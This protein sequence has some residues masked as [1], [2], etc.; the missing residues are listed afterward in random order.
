MKRK[1]IYIFL[2]FL[3]VLICLSLFSCKSD[4]NSSGVESSNTT[5]R[6]NSHKESDTKESESTSSWNNKTLVLVPDASGENTVSCNVSTVDISNT[7][8][9]Y[10]MVNYTGEN[11]KVKLQITGPDAVTYTYDLHGEYEVF[12]LT[13]GS[14]KY[15]V[16]VFENITGTQYSTTLSKKINVDIKNEF[17]PYLYPNQYVNFN[18][19]SL[20]ISKAKELAKNAKNEIEVVEN[21][22]NYIIENYTYDYDKAK[23]VQSGY[24]PV[25]DDIYKSQKGICFDYAALMATMLRCQQIPTR[26]EV[27][28]VGEDY[29]AWIS[30]YI[31]DI[32]WVNGKIEFNGDSWNLLD[33]TFASTSSSPKS[34]ITDNDN[35]LTKYVY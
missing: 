13:A 4:K 12:P 28:Y 6:N 15:T 2:P 16:E 31:D 7:A 17:G 3:T 27:G 9:G 11:P 33:P 22:Y 19:S 30:I 32:G 18:S 35:Y 10:I 25:L 1:K 8:E 21:V 5:I 26:L 20:A 34:F 14:G 23:N 24:L 29:H